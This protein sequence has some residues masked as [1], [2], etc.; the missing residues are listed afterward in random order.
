MTTE[1]LE[2]LLLP[3]GT[4]ELEHSPSLPAGRVSV[5]LEVVPHP[6]SVDSSSSGDWWDYLQRVRSEV[7]ANGGPYRSTEEIEAERAAFRDEVDSLDS[8]PSPEGCSG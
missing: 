4:L 8:P 1:T 3:D 2:G 7:E 5:T 6:P